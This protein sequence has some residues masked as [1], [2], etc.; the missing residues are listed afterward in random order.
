MQGPFRKVI[1]TRSVKLRLS[2]LK[3]AVREVIRTRSAKKK[4]SALKGAV[5]EVIWAR[6]VK[7]RQSSLKKSFTETIQTKKTQIRLIFGLAVRNAT[8][9]KYRSLLL[10]FGILLTVALETGIVVSVDTLY[11]DFIL[12][13][14]NQNYT[15]ITVHPKIWGNLT[16]LKT[17]ARDVQHTS[18]VSKASPVYYTTVNRFLDTEIRANVLLYGIDY[19]THPDFP[20]LNVI[21]GKREVS[22]Y[23]IMISESIQEVAGVEI[24]TLLPLTSL[25]PRFH[26]IEVTVGGVMSNEPFFGNKLLNSFILVDIEILCD[27]VPEDQRLSLLTGEIDVSVDNLVN[28]RKISEN[29]KDNVGFDNYVLVEKNISEIEA[30]GIRSYQTAM[31]LIIIASFIVEFLFIVNILTI[32]IKDRQKEFGILRAVGINTRQLIELIAVEI[33]FYSLIG[34]II[35]V[36]A[37]IGF[38][39]FLVGLLNSFYTSLELQEISIHPSSIFA[40]FMSGIVVALIAGLY[41][42]FLAISMPVI[43]NIHSQMRTAKSINFF[44][45]WKYTV[46]A[47]ILIAITGFYFQFFIGPTRFLDFSIISTHFIVVVFIFLGTLLVEIGI[48]VFLP[49]IGHKLLFWF[50]II[51]R[52]ISMRNITR[53]FQKSLFT[54][55]TSA[56]AL[57]FILVVGLTSTAV[58]ACV[59][60]FYQNQWG[61]IDIVLETMDSEPLSTDFTWYLDART[62]IVRSSF[63]QEMRTEIG[64]I[65]SYVYGVNPRKYSHFAE[66]VIEAINEQ[67]SYSFLNEKNMTIQNTTSG[68][69]KTV[70]VTYGLISQRLYQRFSPYIPLGSNVSVKINSNTTVNITLAAIIQGNAFLG[71]GEY[72]YIASNQFKNHFNTNFAKWFVCD[73]DGNVNT[74]AIALKARY[75]ELKEAIAISQITEM[76]ERS[77]IFQ[78]AIFQVLFIESFILAAMAQFICTLVST[79][80]ME[81]E[82]GIMRSIGLHKRGVIGIFMAES[83]TLGFA[84]L[85]VGLTNGL[86]GSILLAWYIS[87]SIPIEIQFPLDRIFLW[88]LFSFLI[89]L[90]S[91]IL[92]SFRSSRKNIV[93]TISGRPLVKNHVEKQVISFSFDKQG[94]FSPLKE[95]V[96]ESPTISRKKSSLPEQQLSELPPEIKDISEPTTVWQFIRDN[97]L[98]IQTVFLILMIIITS[99]YILENNMI[100]RGLMPFDVILSVIFQIANR[101]LLFINPLLFL[102]GLTS[103]SPITYYFVH[104]N[105]PNS[106]INDV[107]KSI[108]LGLVGIMICSI[109]SFLLFFLFM[110]LFTLLQ[111]VFYGTYSIISMLSL[112]LTIIFQ[113]FIFQRIWAFLI[114]QGANPDL[115]LTHKLKWTRK[116][117]IKGQL[118]FIL[119]VL[120]HA[121]IQAVLFSV[122]QPTPHTGS[123]EAFHLSPLLFLVL[124]IC[125]IGFFLLFIVYQLVQFK[126]HRLAFINTTKAVEK[127]I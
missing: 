51:T 76:M 116:T 58:I 115:P 6:S 122:T 3:G 23:T 71:N 112:V 81:R 92:P 4:V 73:V 34:C 19:K 94:F 8:R 7:L 86:L 72:L 37:G 79:L 5:R 99:N 56:L 47:G 96:S 13:H 17:L 62:Y 100:I 107:A 101:E 60:E 110:L 21:A 93:A 46:G 108:I 127:I 2:A 89:T 59:P 106:L 91:T 16:T 67:P 80:R 105:S 87:L 49:K 22:G 45:N 84:A 114:I 125:E 117:K 31:N 113:L 14:R 28:I 27:I 111:D 119:L 33:L 120:F 109:L 78:A 25:D 85:I 36:V 63:I 32:V 97:K 15:D 104:N 102:L 50:G 42:I 90:A 1:C 41:P 54:I 126:N 38:S 74:I 40:T 61:R 82:M 57:A 123:S 75:T 66:P 95:K 20:H 65:A 43:Q 98:K 29:I 118:G 44:S 10:I 77:L 121:F 26:A 18:G 53:E 35:G 9:S 24:G 55:L 83:I 12:D 48:L 69:T 39:N 103:I 64:G 124:T 70:N 68:V 52:T 30:S 88:V 11:D